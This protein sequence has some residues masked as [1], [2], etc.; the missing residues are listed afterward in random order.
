MHLGDAGTAV[1]LASTVDI[2]KVPLPE[3]KA[4]L[5]LDMARALTQW[6]K[7]DRALDAI[8]SAERY[9]PEEVR[10]RT[11]VHRMIHD[12]A[13]RAPGPVQRQVHRYAETIGVRA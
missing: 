10:S 7:Y 9:A 6:G 1:H 5:M 11:S 12:L 13:R 2:R 3:R 8:R 4:S